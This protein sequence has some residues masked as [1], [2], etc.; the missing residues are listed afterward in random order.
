MMA[1]KPEIIKIL[2]KI[3]ELAHVSPLP[4]RMETQILYS[5]RIHVL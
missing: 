4:G 1:A 3:D 2:H 5:G